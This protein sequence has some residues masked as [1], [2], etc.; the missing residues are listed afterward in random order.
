M[1]DWNLI[2]KEDDLIAMECSVVK[3]LEIMHLL[4]KALVPPKSTTEKSI[5]KESTSATTTRV[6]RPLKLTSWDG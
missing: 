3:D 2:D 5:S 6:T 4:K 1:V